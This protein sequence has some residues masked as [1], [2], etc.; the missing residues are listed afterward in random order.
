MKAL[1]FSNTLSYSWFLNPPKFQACPS[2]FLQMSNWCMEAS[3]NIPYLSFWGSEATEESQKHETLRCAQDDK[4]AFCILFN[5]SVSGWG[6][7]FPAA[8][9]IQFPYRAL[10]L[11]PP[12]SKANFKLVPYNSPL[13]KW[14]VRGDL[15]SWSTDLKWKNFWHS[16]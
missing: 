5:V 8:A 7:F 1:V 12:F 3:E 13:W 9:H 4:K 16:P 10:L 11:N 14:G 6:K 15:G 2:K